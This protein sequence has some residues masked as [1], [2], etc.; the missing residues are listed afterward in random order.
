M[1]IRGYIY[2]LWSIGGIKMLDDVNSL[3][4]RRPK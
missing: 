4:W 1:A 2:Q 3:A